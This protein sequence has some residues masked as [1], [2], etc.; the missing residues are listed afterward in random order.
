MTGGHH[1]TGETPSST[2]ERCL[3]HSCQ[4]CSGVIYAY[5]AN[6]SCVNRTEYRKAILGTEANEYVPGQ[7][8]GMQVRKRL[9]GIQVRVVEYPVIPMAQ[10][11][12][13]DAE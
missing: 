3:R 10:H 4:Q 13:K 11:P 8:V 6:G 5:Q 1:R 12:G 2:D 9:Q 7:S